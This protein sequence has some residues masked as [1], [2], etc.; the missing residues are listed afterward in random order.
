MK[1]TSNKIYITDKNVLKKQ[2]ILCILKTRN[3]HVKN[4]LSTNNNQTFLRIFYHLYSIMFY[5]LQSRY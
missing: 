3:L 2:I 5:D 4:I 1:S